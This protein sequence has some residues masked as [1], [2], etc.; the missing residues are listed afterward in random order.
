MVQTADV[1]VEF[2]DLVGKMI[3]SSYKKRIDIQGVATHPWMAGRKFSAQEKQTAEKDALKET[4]TIIT[5]DTNVNPST[6]TGTKPANP[7]EDSGD[8]Y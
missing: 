4:D 5:G 8:Q 1:S 7:Y 2:V 3:R 6:N